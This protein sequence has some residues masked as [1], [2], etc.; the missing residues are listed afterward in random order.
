MAVVYLVEKILIISNCHQCNNEESTRQQNLCL[1]NDS[2]DKLD[3][4]QK[5]VYQHIIFLLKNEI[6]VSN[7]WSNEVWSFFIKSRSEKNIASKASHASV[8]SKPSNFAP[9]LQHLSCPFFLLQVFRAYIC[10]F[11][12]FTT[13]HHSYHLHET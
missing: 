11:S 12:N 4:K 13:L 9:N 2:K 10:C 3:C 5:S 8:T 1:I 6:T 7:A